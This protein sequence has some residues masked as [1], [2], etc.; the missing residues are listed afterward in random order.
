MLTTVLTSLLYQQILSAHL[1]RIWQSDHGIEIPLSSFEKLRAAME[2]ET[3]FITDAV[4]DANLGYAGHHCGGGDVHEVKCRLVIGLD[5][6]VAS[7][8]T[9]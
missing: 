7:R 8:E 3:V 9:R 6:I 5:E 4:C 1:D 2:H